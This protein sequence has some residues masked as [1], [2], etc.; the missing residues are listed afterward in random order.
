MGADQHFFFF[1]LAVGYGVVV[2]MVV[3]VDRHR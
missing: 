2:A 3:W 1:F